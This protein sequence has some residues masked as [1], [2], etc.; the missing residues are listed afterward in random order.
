MEKQGFCWNCDWNFVVAIKGTEKRDKN[1]A[2][3]Q[4][5]IIVKGLKWNG[6]EWYERMKIEKQ[7]I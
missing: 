6:M 7:I 4:F 5:S 2:E 1:L 3:S